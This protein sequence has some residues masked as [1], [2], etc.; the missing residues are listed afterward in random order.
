MD[1]DALPFLGGKSTR[2]ITRDDIRRILHRVWDR[3]AEYG[4]ARLLA[5]LSRMFRWAVEQGI[6][7]GD[8]TVGLQR[9][10]RPRKKGHFQ[11]VTKN[12]ERLAEILR[13][14][15]D[16]PHLLARSALQL[17]ALTLA[18]PGEVIAMKWDEI[19]LRARTWTRMVS[20][21]NRELVCPLPTQAVAILERLRVQTGHLPHVFAGR[22][23][24][25]HMAINTPV[26]ALK[27]AGILD[28]TAH[29]FRATGRTMLDEVL[30]ERPDII[31]QTLGHTVRAP[32]GTAYARMAFIKQRRVM[33]QRWADYLDS[34]RTGGIALGTLDA[35]AG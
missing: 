16:I 11:A 22:A 28:H 33:M 30:E 19:D 20:K 6:T 2:D 3:G 8:P 34:L 29:G 5:D 12:P 17:L 18:R 32:N 15:E 13:T 31:E 9:S 4:A 27:R 26:C 35:A 14:I 7:L 10:F 25:T 21:V 24:N 23:K 1:R